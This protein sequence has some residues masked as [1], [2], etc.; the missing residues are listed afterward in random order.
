M[1]LQWV[2]N[3]DW[4]TA[5]YFDDDGTLRGILDDNEDGIRVEIGF[6]DHSELRAW[7]GY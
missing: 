4:G 5:A 1:K 3:H 6:H 7:A 2:H